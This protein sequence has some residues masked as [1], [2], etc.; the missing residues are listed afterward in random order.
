MKRCLLLLLALLTV[1]ACAAQDTAE[2]RAAAL[3]SRY[4][5]SDGCKARVEA[6]V[7]SGEEM[8][9]YVLDMEQS[10][11]ET[12]VTVCEPEALAGISAVLHRGAPLTLAYDGTVLDAGNADT[13]V[14]AANASDVVLRAI[15]E[16]CLTECGTAHCGDTV[17]ALRLCFETEQAGEKLLVAVWFDAADAPLYAEIEFRGE[18]LAYLQFTDFT[19]RDKIPESSSQKRDV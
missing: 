17:D 5:A 8:R 12:R 1:S 10:D 15:A 9:Q 2:D 6:D 13:P 14:N 11:D 16:G 4:A 18:I 19:F 3:Q 7:A